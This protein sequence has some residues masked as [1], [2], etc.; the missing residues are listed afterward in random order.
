MKPGVYAFWLW[1]GILSRQYGYPAVPSKAGM[2]MSTRPIKTLLYRPVPAEES[3]A[4]LGRGWIKSASP[5]SDV[6]SFSSP[7]L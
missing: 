4:D 3:A 1:P 2:G 5:E 7:G 6:L